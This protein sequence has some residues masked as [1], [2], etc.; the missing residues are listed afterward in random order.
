MYEEP[1]YARD[2]EFKKLIVRQSDVDLTRVALEL[3]RDAYPG[4]DLD[5]SCEWIKARAEEL[6]P[7]LAVRSELET[8]A[9]LSACLSDRY[10]LTGSPEAYEDPDSSFLNRVIETGQGIPI[11]LSVIYMAVAEELDLPLLGASAPMHFLTRLE[12]SQG[13]MFVDAYAG[14]RVLTLLECLDWLKGLTNLSERRL[15]EALEPVGPRAI[16]VR[17]LNNLKVLYAKNEN[18]PAAWKVQHRLSALQRSSYNER[19]D[20][21]IISLHAGRLSLAVDVLN[22]C[23]QKCPKE[24]K[25]IL[26]GHLKEAQRQLSEWN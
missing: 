12:T 19:R 17:M 13:T 11:S 2:T 22:A 21:G 25:P 9:A 15:I 14:G 20:L 10:G 16:I 8:L 7:G 26:E 5:E 4:L 1:N 3:A 6:R 18:W 24:E 23:L